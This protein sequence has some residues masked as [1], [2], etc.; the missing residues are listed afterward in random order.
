[1]DVAT[2]AHAL[3]DP[4]PNVQPFV[5]QGL[6]HYSTQ[7]PA[8]EV[9]C[10]ELKYHSTGYGRLARIQIIIITSRNSLIKG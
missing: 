8:L 3:E 9:F 7:C 4:L 2:E 5:S 1:M 10:T 6:T